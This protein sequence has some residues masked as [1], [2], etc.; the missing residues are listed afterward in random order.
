MFH[1]KYQ[2]ISDFLLAAIS[3]ISPLL[4]L[5]VQHLLTPLS[6]ANLPVYYQHQLF[7]RVTDWWYGQPWPP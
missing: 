1:N 4:S 2:Q 3:T 7:Y 6:T 5:I